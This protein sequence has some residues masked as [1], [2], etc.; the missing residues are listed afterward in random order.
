MRTEYFILVLNPIEDQ[1]TKGNWD[2]FDFKTLSELKNKMRE[3]EKDEVE[4]QAIVVENGI[5]REI[6]SSK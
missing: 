4:Y 1:K 2:R 5:S 3:C 6:F